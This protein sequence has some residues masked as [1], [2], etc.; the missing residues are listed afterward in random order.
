MRYATARYAS[1]TVYHYAAAN[2]IPTMKCDM[3]IYVAPSVHNCAPE[4][5]GRFTKTEK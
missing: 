1:Q 4:S 3:D 2:E 5:K